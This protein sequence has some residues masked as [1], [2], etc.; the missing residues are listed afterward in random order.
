MKLVPNP[1]GTLRREVAF[2]GE[3]NPVGESRAKEAAAN[4]QAD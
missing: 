2:G 4:G 3:S 1:D